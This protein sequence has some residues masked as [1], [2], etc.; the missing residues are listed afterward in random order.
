MPSRS[1]DSLGTWMAGAT[2]LGGILV[3]PFV[4]GG[5]EPMDG[6]GRATQEQLPRGDLGLCSV[7]AWMAGAIKLGGISIKVCYNYRLFL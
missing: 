4:K 5:Y 1:S 7:G 6:R 3:P 2:N